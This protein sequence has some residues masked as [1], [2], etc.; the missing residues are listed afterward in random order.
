LALA[1]WL[2]S[3]LLQVGLFA[4]PTP[5]GAPFAL[6]WKLSLLNALLY[7]LLGTFIVAAPFLV[8]WILVYRRQVSGWRWDAVHVAQVIVLGANLLLSHVDHELMRF[9][10]LHFTWSFAQTYEP[11]Q[12][13][14]SVMFDSLLLDRGGPGL[15]I[16]LGLLVPGA[17]LL[18][19]RRRVG[20]GLGLATAARSPH[21]ALAVLTAV[22]P[23]TVTCTV[24]QFPGAQFKLQRIQ[25]FI[26]TSWEEIVTGLSDLVEPPRFAELVREY[27]DG[28]LAESADRGWRFIDPALP[29]LRAPVGAPRPADAG[30]RWNVIYLQVETLRGWDTPLLR[31]ELRVSP[32]PFLDSLATSDRAAYWAHYLSF[33]PPT[34]DNVVAAHCSVTPH[35][36]RHITTTFTA[37]DFYSFPEALRRRGYRAEMFSAADPDWDNQTQSLKG[38]Y[39]RVW[40]YQDVRERDRDVFHRAARRIRDMGAHGQ[41]FLATVV[42]A[43]N[44]YPFRNPEPSLDIAGNE[45]VE[46]RILNTLHYTDDV[47]REFVEALRTQP[48]FERTILVIAGDHGYNLGE[49]DGTPGQASLHRESLWVPLI[50]YGA[51]PR[52]P[53]GRQ[54]GLASHLDLA[55]TVT[56]LLGIREPNPWRG[57]SLVAGAGPRARVSFGR[58]DML[59]V[60]TPAWSLFTDAKTGLP[61]LFD[62]EADPLQRRNI[63]AAH[64]LELNRMLRQAEAERL[65]NDHLI[66]MGRVWKRR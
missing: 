60:E 22:L 40:F 1:A 41:P 59:L 3:A 32:T 30:P 54:D 61:C 15:P 12:A 18:W 52:M 9:M 33:G 10:G 64:M 17:Y 26:V 35:S 6:D 4:R 20:R 48:W 44:H 5:Y 53:S 28:W 16:L 38:W 65:L 36:R 37:V 56:D 55:P 8:L 29:Y 2:G 50:I 31:P 62:V 21:F 19:G 34:V 45:K 42:S 27:Q 25:P 46:Q 11:W 7:D 63:S 58:G 57:H 13:P 51:H 47:I 39:D 23:L 49:H 24:R 14:P 66:R 43:T